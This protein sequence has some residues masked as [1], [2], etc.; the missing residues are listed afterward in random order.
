MLGIEIG[1]GLSELTTN[2]NIDHWPLATHSYCDGDRD[3]VM[4]GTL[5]YVVFLILEKSTGKRIYIAIYMLKH[6]ILH[7]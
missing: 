6:V 5:L 2:F 4:Y 1:D 7:T 3:V